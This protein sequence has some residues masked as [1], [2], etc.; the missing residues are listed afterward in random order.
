MDFFKEV[1]LPFASVVIFLVL[2]SLFLVHTCEKRSCAYYEKVTGRSTDY[3][4]FGGCFVETDSGWLT[5]NEYSQ[6]II[7]RE[8]LIGRQ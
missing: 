2:V 3:D 6:V 4:F 1:W 8:G 5:K 7:A